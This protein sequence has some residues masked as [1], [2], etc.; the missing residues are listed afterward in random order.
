MKTNKFIFYIK[1]ITRMC[2]YNKFRFFLAVIGLFVGL[3]VF[4]S[5]NI[6]MDSYYNESIKNAS[7]MEENV[8][9]LKYEATEEINK[10]DIYGKQS[11]PTLESVFSSEKPLIYVKKYTNDTM[12]ALTAN[13]IGVSEI[14]SVIPIQYTDEEYI[15]AKPTLVKG[16]MINSSDIAQTNNVAI[17]DEF[18]ESLLFPAKDS[19]GK[20]IIFNIEIPGV[21]NNSSKTENVPEIRKCTVIGVISCG[22][23][24]LQERMKYNKYISGLANSIN[25]N[26]VIYTPK[27]YLL[28]NYKM[29]AKKIIAWSSNDTS[30]AQQIKE[31]ISLYKNQSLKEFASYDI[32]DKNTVLSQAKEELEPLRIFLALIMVVLLMISGINAMSTMFF[33][34]K[35]RI[36]EIGIKKA[37]G[38]TKVEIL[39]QFII[40]GM[41]MA[42]IASI[43]T[44]VLSAITVLV[45]QKYLNEKL[46]VL[47]E[48]N[49]TYS[50]ILLPIFV[51]IIYGFIFSVIPSYYGAKIK[52]TD[53]LRFE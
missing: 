22:Y 8:V 50:N 44:V 35:E 24:G 40:E 27:S 26:T 23:H 1:H 31:S 19:I 29:S 7:Q 9:A 28:E 20:Q 52:V 14:S 21:S 15:L 30:E 41:M 43:F 46:F 53:S 38:A 11:T 3:F 36:N 51:A 33:S 2:F 13:I 4:T 48:I 49:L 6:L 32:V 17:I 42:F 37:L 10:N 25:L 34:V 12:C 47:F 18:T 16:R 39:N 45:L 5:G